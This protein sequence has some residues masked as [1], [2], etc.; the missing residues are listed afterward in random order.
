[1]AAIVE[2]LSSEG[3]SVQVRSYLR[4]WHGVWQKSARTLG[5]G[6]A[7]NA[8]MANPPVTIRLRPVMV[9]Y[10]EDLGRIGPYGKGR[11]GVIRRFIE[12]GIQRAIERKVIEKR[13]AVDFGEALEDEEEEE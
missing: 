6:P 4:C 5:G 1:M 9:A 7:A 12:N 2:M 10:L 3:R 11:A 8:V 13:D